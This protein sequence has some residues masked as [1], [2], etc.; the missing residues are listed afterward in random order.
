MDNF[1]DYI[2]DEEEIA[3]KMEIVYYLSKKTGIFFDK[4]VVFKTELLRLFLNYS[5]INVDNNMLLTASLLCN[6]KKSTEAQDINKIHSYAKEG[7]Q[8]LSGLGFGKKFCKICEEIN[9]YS[10]SNPREKESD[11]LELIDNFGGMLL[12]RPERIGFKPDEALVLLEHRN[13]KNEYN[14]YLNTFIDF[15]NFIES[16]KISDTSNATVLRKLVKYY[17]EATEVTEFIKKVIYKFEPK[18]DKK[19]ENKKIPEGF[20]YTKVNSLRK[21]AV[22]KLEFYR[23]INIGQASRISGVSPADISVLLIYM[24]QHKNN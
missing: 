10:N 7:A 16:V 18:A 9:R 24:E 19:I 6:C 21:E 4:S 17:N 8:Y 14:R 11:I 2:L 13:L 15:V 20:D 12:D 23:P 3:S 22:Q 5:K 1:A